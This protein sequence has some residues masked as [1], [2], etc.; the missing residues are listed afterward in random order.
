MYSCCSQQLSIDK[1]TFAN[2]KQYFVRCH[3]NAKKYEDLINLYRVLSVGQAV[4]FC[5]TRKTALWLAKKMNEDKFPVAL[6]VGGLDVEQRASILQ[7]QAL[8]F[9]LITVRFSL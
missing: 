5:R 2:V 8:L 6:L 1:E 7:R 3:S 9:L 4:F